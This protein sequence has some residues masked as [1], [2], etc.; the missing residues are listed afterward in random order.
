M[1]LYT[2][3]ASTLEF[4]QNTQ[5]TRNEGVQEVLLPRRERQPKQT[6]NTEVI[7]MH[8]VQVK[9]VRLV[10]E[11]GRV[12]KDREDGLVFLQC[13]KNLQGSIEVCQGFPTSCAMGL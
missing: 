5:V 1:L 8:E 4:S 12:E 3:E 11:Q 2:L 7:L 6:Q 10:R 9:K 13:K